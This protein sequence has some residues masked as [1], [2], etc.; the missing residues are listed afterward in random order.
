MIKERLNHLAIDRRRHASVLK[1]SECV[2]GLQQVYHASIVFRKGPCPE[3][4]LLR[5][6]AQNIRDVAKFS[7]V[8]ALQHFLAQGAVLDSLTLS[9]L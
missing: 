6:G 7:G 4:F 8:G 5:N 2:K 9:K 3:R 1:P